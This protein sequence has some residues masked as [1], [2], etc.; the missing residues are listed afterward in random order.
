MQTL[1]SGSLL[2]EISDPTAAL[3]ASQIKASALPG[4]TYCESIKSMLIFACWTCGYVGNALALSTYPQAPHVRHAPDVK[5][6]SVLVRIAGGG[7]PDG[8]RGLSGLRKA[9]R[10]L[11]TRRTRGVF[12]QG[13]FCA[14]AVDVRFFRRCDS[15]QSPYRRWFCLWTAPPELVLASPLRVSDRSSAST[16]ARLVLP[17]D[18]LIS[19]SGG[20]TSTEARATLAQ[21]DVRYRLQPTTGVLS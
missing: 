21:R 18:P 12:L 11:S 8:A 7:S 9:E 16:I 3:S 1:L 2:H 5:A 6:A 19:A 10:R 13:C 15:V 14:C 17:R 20:K 4:I